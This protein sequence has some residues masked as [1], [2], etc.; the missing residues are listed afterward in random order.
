M[1]R[2]QLQQMLRRYAEEFPDEADVARRIERLVAEHADCFERSCRPGHITGSAWVLSH[3]RAKCLLVHHGRLDRWLQPG[4]HAD[5][6]TDVA[7]VAHREAQEETGLV[8]IELVATGNELIP[9]DLDV[10]L[11]PPRLDAEG[12][13]V[14][15]A[16]EHH[17]IRFLLIA[18]PGQELVTSDESHDVRWF[19]HEEVLAATDEESVL[20]MLRK[21]GPHRNC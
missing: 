15:D 5:G 12:R 6:Q 8:D 17:D 16:H 7:A 1:H 19:T 9:L 2:Q 14:E 4:G 21:A 13:E 10:H 18:A 20:R 11:I 3:D